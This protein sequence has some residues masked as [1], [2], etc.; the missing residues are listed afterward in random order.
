MAACMVLQILPNGVELIYG[1][2]VVCEAFP[3]P[4]NFDWSREIIRYRFIP[5]T[6]TLFRY[7]KNVCIWTPMRNDM[8]LC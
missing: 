5:G 7:L 2:E 6:W 1:D 3:E 8:K 4:Y